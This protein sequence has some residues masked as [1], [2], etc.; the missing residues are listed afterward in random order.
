[1]TST[2][3]DRDLTTRAVLRIRNRQNPG[4]VKMPVDDLEVIVM[5]VTPS[6]TPKGIPKLFMTGY[7]ATYEDGRLRIGGADRVRYK[8][9]AAIGRR[10]CP[11]CYELEYRSSPVWE[12]GP[13]V[14]KCKHCSKKVDYLTTAFSP[15]FSYYRGDSETHAHISAGTEYQ[16]VADRMKDALLHGQERDVVLPTRL[17]ELRGVYFVYCE[18]PAFH[19]PVAFSTF[20]FMLKGQYGNTEYDLS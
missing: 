20:D 10:I 9:N 5:S 11:A 14:G 15:Y 7:G 16:V 18:M 3:G 2:V 1:M 4:V 8:M 17:C 12:R 13:N 6:P 19:Q